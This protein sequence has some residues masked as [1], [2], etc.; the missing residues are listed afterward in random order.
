V[1]PCAPSAKRSDRFD[2]ATSTLTPPPSVT[3]TPSTTAKLEALVGSQ[4]FLA[5]S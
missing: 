1:A 4:A 5:G 2:P 3:A